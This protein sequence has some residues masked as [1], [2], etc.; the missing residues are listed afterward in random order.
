M[1]GEVPCNANSKVDEKEVIRQI[2]TF[3]DG[4]HR[5]GGK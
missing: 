5:L 4:S 1:I 2:V 3:G